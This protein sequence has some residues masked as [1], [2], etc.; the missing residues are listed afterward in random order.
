ML[1]GFLLSLAMLYNFCW[2]N[3]I[4]N[5]IDHSFFPHQHDHSPHWALPTTAGMHRPLASACRISS[6]SSIWATRGASCIIFSN[7]AAVLQPTVEC[8]TC[9]CVMHASS[10]HIIYTVLYWTCMNNY[11]IT[12]RGGSLHSPPAARDTVV[13]WHLG[14]HKSKG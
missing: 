6:Y 11:Y 2:I 1:S 9:I 13:F 4:S 7:K 10:C 5:I 14:P 12:N 8:H 3:Y